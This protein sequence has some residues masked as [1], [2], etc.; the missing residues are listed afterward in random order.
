[1]I[2]RPSNYTSIPLA[3][4]RGE[5]TVNPR[6]WGWRPSRSL[7]M[8]TWRYSRRIRRYWGQNCGS[9]ESFQVFVCR[10]WIRLRRSSCRSHSREIEPTC[11][12]QAPVGPLWTPPYPLFPSSS[13]PPCSRRGSPKPPDDG[14]SHLASEPQANTGPLP[15]QSGSS[16]PSSTSGC[17]AYRSPAPS[18]FAMI[19]VLTAGTR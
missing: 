15:L 18:S 5:R 8:G 12:C 16:R 6:A 17:D 2:F 19:S 11:T 14:T 1:M 4:A 10:Q 13:G 3:K 9:S 7:I